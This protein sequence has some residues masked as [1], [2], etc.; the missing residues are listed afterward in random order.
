V[1][2]KYD[3]KNTGQRQF[4]NQS[5]KR[6]EAEPEIELRPTYIVS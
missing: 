2:I 1:V 3:G 4:Q 6:R 5:G